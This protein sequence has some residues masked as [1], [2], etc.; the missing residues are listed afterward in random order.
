MQS[1]TSLFFFNGLLLLNWMVDKLIKLLIEYSH[2]LFRVFDTHFISDHT[3]LDSVVD[4]VNRK[5]KDH[6]TYRGEESEYA[7]AGVVPP[8]IALRPSC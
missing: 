5:S 2:E 1:H 3:N 6:V 7:V 4:A 8:L